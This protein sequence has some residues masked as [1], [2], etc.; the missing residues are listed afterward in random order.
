MKIGRM[1]D[2]EKYPSD[3]LNFGVKLK[4]IKVRIQ[5][6]LQYVENVINKVPRKIVGK[7]QSDVEILVFNTSFI[8]N[9][10]SVSSAQ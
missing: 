2:L 4:G 3:L 1:M 6:S 5:K 8:E 9:P 10:A 7:F